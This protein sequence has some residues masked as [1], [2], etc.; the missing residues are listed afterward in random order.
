MK[1]FEVQ[2]GNQ[3]IKY[4]FLKKEGLKAHYILVDPNKGVILK[5]ASLSVTQADAIILKKAKWILKK[6]ALMKSVATLDQIVTGIQVQYLGE[7]YEV[8]LQ[9]NTT[10]KKMKI[11]LSDTKINIYCQSNHSQQQLK[12]ALERFFNQRAKE[13]IIPKVEQWS[14]VT[15]LKYTTLKFR[16]MKRRWGSC[17]HDNQITLNSAAIQLPIELIDYLIVHELSHIKVKNHSKEFWTEVA[18]YIPNWKEL[19]TQIK[20]IAIL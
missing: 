10:S 5:G 4:S 14:K 7:K 11:E 6:L 12:L 16:K 8:Q 1:V 3:T 20:H 15:N 19:D 13:V 2:Y 18:N 9:K 17:T